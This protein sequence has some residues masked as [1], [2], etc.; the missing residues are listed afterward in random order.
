[1]DVYRKKQQ[2]DAA[3]LPDPVISPL[4]RYRQLMDPSTDRWPAFPTS[5]QRTL[6]GIM[7]QTTHAAAPTFRTKSKPGTSVRERGWFDRVE[8]YQDIFDSCPEC[9]NGTVWLGQRDEDNLI[10]L[11]C[12]ECASH[13]LEVRRID[14]GW[15]ILPGREKT[16][17][18]EQVAGP[19]Q[20]SER[21]TAEWNRK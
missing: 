8:S 19:N 17:G 9:L 14:D 3:S 10:E 4:R 6:A 2:W 13:W 15:W 7:L 5:D 16:S 20:G 11:K 1:M 18:W 12:S 21:T